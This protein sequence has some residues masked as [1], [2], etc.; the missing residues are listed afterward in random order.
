[1]IGPLQLCFIADAL[2][3]HRRMVPTVIA[4]IQSA[5][6]DERNREYISS[7]KYYNFLLSELMPFVQT[8]YRI[9]SNRVGIGGV[10][11]GAV[12]AAHAAL[13]NPAV[14][15]R[16]LMVSPPLGKGEYQDEL[17]E[18]SKRFTGA[19]RLP[20]R[21][22]QSVGH[23]EAKARFNRPAHNLKSILEGF[24]TVQYKFVETGSGHG[25]VGFRSV[26]P[27]ALAWMFPGDAV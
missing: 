25:L 17:R 21:I 24:S 1:M 26:L 10:A 3:K 22:F 15:S 9:D 13:K 16:L 23:Y 19:E 6:Q 20:D 8:H 7:D 5:T 2:I 27:E 12:A 14:F 11:V 4:M 18:Y